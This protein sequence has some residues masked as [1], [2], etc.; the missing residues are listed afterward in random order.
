MRSGSGNL[1]VIDTIVIMGKRHR[2][3][4]APCELRARAALGVLVRS[5]VR[6]HAPIICVG[7]YYLPDSSQAAAEV[8]KETAI[9]LGV[10]RSSFMARRETN[11]TFREVRVIQAILKQESWEY[12]AVITHPYHVRR[13]SRYFCEVGIRPQMIGCTV[14]AGSQWSDHGE[15]TAAKAL[16]AAGSLRP[17]EKL[18]ELVVE[19]SLS[20]LHRLDKAGSI[21]CRLA[22]IVRGG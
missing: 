14:E 5:R 15:C 22:D 2:Q 10:P 17:P 7:G 13:T 19:S 3:G 8:A 1:A 12:P 16:I 9:G 11:C 18:K 4:Q 20:L 21:E 6:P